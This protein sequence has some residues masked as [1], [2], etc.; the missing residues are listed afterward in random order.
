LRWAFACVLAGACGDLTSDPSSSALAITEQDTV[1]CGAGPTVKGIDVSAYQGLI[2]WAAARADGVEYAFIRASDGT[3]FLDAQFDRNWDAVRA[4]GILRGAYQFFRPDQDP[5]AQAD[6]L[7]GKI[8][9]SP[10]DLPPVIDVEDAGG[11]PPDAVAAA[12]GAW[13]DRVRPVIGREPII[14]TG[15]YFWRDQVGAADMTASPLWHAQYTTADC[16]NIA[17]PWP[18]WAFWQYTATGA[19]A[20]IAGAVDI[21][22]FNGTREDLATFAAGE[23]PCGIIGPEGGQIDD[24][25]ACFTG[26]GP[27]QYLRKVAGAGVDGD[28]VWTYATASSSEV[29]FGHWDLAFAEAGRYRLEVS[30]PAPYAAS[31]RARYVV[32]AAGA[33]HEIVLDQAASSD[34]QPLAI[35]DFAAGGHQWVHLGDNTGDASSAQV[36]LAFD[37][38]RLVRVPP[39]AELP[40]I[41]EGGAGSGHGGCSAGGSGGP[42][43]GAL[44][45]ALGL[46]ARRRRPR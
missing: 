15:F 2:D 9:N 44:A 34:W 8:A 12:V 21:D 24:G 1:V 18:D 13:L 3:S 37:A 14:Y 25:D 30:T 20:G 41:D 5:I 16:P 39:D 23:R 35:L 28:L 29:S 6:L 38:I 33:R 46:A 19:V 11:L 7:L 31:H 26:G 45:L 4:Q 27:L 22:R 36:Q 42:G 10:G 17:P 32:S 43:L 40:P